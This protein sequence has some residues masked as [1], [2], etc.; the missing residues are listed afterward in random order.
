MSRQ[1]TQNTGP[2]RALRAAMFRLGLRYRV[3]RRPVPTLRGM[4]DIVFP[5]AKVAVFV[6]GCYWHGCSEHRTVPRANAEF[7]R[8]KLEGNRLRDRQIDTGLAQLGW[9]VVRVWEHEE[10]GPVALRIQQLV[11]ERRSRRTR[12]RVT[13]I[14]ARA[15]SS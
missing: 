9:V 5:S 8:A 12:D 11:Q 3:Q 6:D 4:A 7:W 14:R 10:V 1:A 13:P 2:E 15:P